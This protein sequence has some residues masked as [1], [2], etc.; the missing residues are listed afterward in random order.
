MTFRAKSSTRR[1]DRSRDT[2]RRT[3][4]TNAVFALI[5]AIAVLILLAAAA[6]TYY[7][8]HLAAVATV[9]GHVINKDQLRDRY[10]VDV[11]RINSVESQIRN[12]VSSGRLTKDQGDQQIQLV[13]QQKANTNTLLGQ[14]VQNLINAELQS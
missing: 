7:G 4:A 8:D 1:G 6:A 9:N 3:V 10:A 12:A 11:W 5:I 14:S 2:G 13:E